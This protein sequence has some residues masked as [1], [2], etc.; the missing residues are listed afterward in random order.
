MPY[1]GP[2]DK[3]LPDSVKKMPRWLRNI[4][5]DAFNSVMESEDPSTDSGR[6][7]AEAKAFPIA[8][9]A[10]RKAA[11][12]K[13]KKKM[14]EGQK[15]E[16][17][18]Q[19]PV[20]IGLKV[21]S[22]A[23]GSKRWLSVSS[24]GYQ[25]REREIVSTAFL[26]DAIERAEQMND[27]GDLRIYH[28]PGSRI[29]GCDYQAVSDGFLLE[30]GLFDDN[31]AGKAG[32][33]FVEAHPDTK[34]SIGFAYRHRTADGVYIPPGIILERSILP[35]DAAAFPWATITLTET[36]MTTIT[37]A[38]RKAL[39]DILGEEVAGE[40]LTGL[41]AAAKNLQES[42]VR[43]KEMTDE[44]GNE[45]GEA[46]TE[47]VAPVDEPVAELA[48]EVAPVAAI[49]PALGGGGGSAQAQPEQLMDMDFELSEQALD[50]IASRLWGRIE[51]LMTKSITPLVDQ[52]GE[53]RTV[54]K[55]MSADVARLSETEDARIA[56]KAA[57]LP[58]ATVRR[59]LRPTQRSE[60]A[61]EEQLETP[62]GANGNYLDI[63]LRTLHGD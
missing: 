2:D 53:L 23:D 24:G 6:S 10:V 49:E 36:D 63:G 39:D 37:E 19:T 60:K 8:L 54:T 45:T 7:A 40:V 62:Q 3:S 41:E 43:F 9:A 11:D 35:P 28:I 33:A 21:F 27:R 38:K 25:D 58:R 48:A 16:D 4:F 15:T 47:A 14:T 46:V 56:E 17:R 44:P 31:R 61:L 42:G 52:V 26:E 5:A 12:A 1:S 55:A 29:G 34:I 51:G 57:D 18:G 50:D 13:G 20:R 22:Q 32:A 59:I 30:S